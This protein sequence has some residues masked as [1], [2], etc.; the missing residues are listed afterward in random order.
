MGPPAS[1]RSTAQTIHVTMH[2]SRN[3]HSGPGSHASSLQKFS[4]K[5]TYHVALFA[6]AMR[7]KNL[8]LP[9]PPYC[10]AF[11]DVFLGHDSHSNNFSSPREAR[12]FDLFL[13]SPSPMAISPNAFCPIL[14]VHRTSFNLS[15]SIETVTQTWARIFSLGVAI[16][17]IRSASFILLTISPRLLL[18]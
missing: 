3:S 1:R 11:R 14:C 13:R 5:H 10:P 18:C 2:S 8:L 17:S 4:L 7:Q 16:R 12:N 9:L 15:E 6:R